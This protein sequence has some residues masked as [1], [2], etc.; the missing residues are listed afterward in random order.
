M[1]SP[2]M[3]RLCVWSGEDS[4][5]DDEKTVSGEKSLPTP[6]VPAVRVAKPLGKAYR[7]N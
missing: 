6:T 5:T 4:D 7:E 1:I 3:Q 2:P